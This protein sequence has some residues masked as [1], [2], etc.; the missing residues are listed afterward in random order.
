MKHILVEC[1]YFLRNICA[2]NIRNRTVYV[3]IN[4]KSKVGR[5][6]LRHIVVSSV[7]CQETG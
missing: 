5:F 7:L 1:T 4:S 2:K 3:K 6:F